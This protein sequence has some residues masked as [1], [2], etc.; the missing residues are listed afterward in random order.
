MADTNKKSINE[1]IDDLVASYLSTKKDAST[2]G[3]TDFLQTDSKTDKEP[4]KDKDKEFLERFAP[5]YNEQKQ[6]IQ[7]LEAQLNDYANR[8][9]TKDEP[10][11]K[12]KRTPKYNPKELVDKIEENFPEGIEFAYKSEYGFSPLEVIQAL[13]QKVNLIE[14]EQNINKFVSK[15]K[16]YDDT[17]P[18]HIKAI[19]QIMQA[20]RSPWT[21][22]NI[23]KSWALAKHHGIV[24]LGRVSDP[25]KEAARELTNTNGVTEMKPR[26]GIPSVGSSIPTNFKNTDKLDREFLSKSPDEQREIL[27]NLAAQMDKLAS[28][29]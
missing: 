10:P 16:D 14:T 21:Y 22:D 3:D 18:D 11:K 17:N 8:T 25:I 13:A 4:V 6:R 1:E 27:A 9:V 2:G 28:N 7:Q 26:T 29:G 15:T 23:E 20:S 24:T 12:E 5:V 19:A